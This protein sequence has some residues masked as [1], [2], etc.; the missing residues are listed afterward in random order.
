[1]ISFRF[2]VDVQGGPGCSG[3]EGNFGEM[4]PWRIGEDVQL[5][6]NSN[7]WNRRF[8]VLYI[9]SPAGTGFSIAPSSDAIVTNQYQVARDL[10]EALMIFF[11]DCVNSSRALY[12][13]GESYGGKFVPALG[14]YIISNSRK[15]RLNTEQQLFKLHGVAIGNGLTHPI[16]QVETYGATAYYMGLVDK[17]QKHFLDKLAKKVYTTVSH[18]H[19]T[20]SSFIILST[21][22]WQGYKS[23]SLQ[24]LKEC[25]V[26]MHEV[27]IDK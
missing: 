4:G 19:S 6:K 3:L 13:T 7:P 22:A 12:I 17:K 25:N 20:L 18:L 10:Y 23:L 5:H 9:D 16:V 21:L 11:S 14:Y 1:M 27:F 26:F 8:G 24:I 2:A 15:L